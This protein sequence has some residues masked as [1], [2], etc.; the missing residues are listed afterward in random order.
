MTVAC[1]SESELSLIRKRH[2][3]WFSTRYRMW[4][5]PCLASLNF[6]VYHN[7]GFKSA[8]TVRNVKGA[9]RVTDYINTHTKKIQSFNYKEDLALFRQ[10]K[11][12]RNRIDHENSKSTAIQWRPIQNES[13]LKCSFVFLSHHLGFHFNLH[14]CIETHNLQLEKTWPW[15]PCCIFAIHQTQK[16]TAHTHTVCCDFADDCSYKANST[17]F[18]LYTHTITV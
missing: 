12:Y 13:T 9:Y 7:V 5:G 2:F 10:T 16:N 15:P 6:K 4:C 14:K 3:L 11:S 18:Y 17:H 8:C 1:T